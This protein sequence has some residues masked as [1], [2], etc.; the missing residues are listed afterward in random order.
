[1]NRNDLEATLE[2]GS[3]TETQNSNQPLSDTPQ[4]T[5]SCA[6]E[7]TQ[8]KVQETRDSSQPLSSRVKIIK[9]Y[10]NRKLYDTEKSSYVVLK[11]IKKMI[12]NKENIRVIDNETQKDITVATLIQIIFS[13]EK[14]SRISP[15][16][17]ILHSVIRDGDGGFSSF[18]AKLGLFTPE[19]SQVDSEE[20]AHTSFST[21]KDSKM[22]KKKCEPLQN[23]EQSLVSL[24]NSDES[25]ATE[26]S[27]PQLPGGLG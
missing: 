13:A 5:R 2:K 18:L 22:K 10:G 15:P 3:K 8:N 7:P 20:D 19:V 11:D 6:E 21:S 24:A 25:K 12:Y 14:K 23:E 16:L 9:R 1:M 4:E 26:S 27:V 17:E